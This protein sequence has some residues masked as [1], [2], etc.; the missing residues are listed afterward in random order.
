MKTLTLFL[1]AFASASAA[2]LTLIA[3]ASVSPTMPGINQGSATSL[4]AF[5]QNRTF[6]QFDAKGSLPAGTVPSHI[7][8][9]VLRLYVEQVSG[10]LP[11]KATVFV[12]TANGLWT[13]STITYANQPSIG[14]P[15]VTADAATDRQ[16]LAV[17]V[18]ELVRDQL[19]GLVSL[20]VESPDVALF[21]ASKESS[22]GMP[23][24]LDVTLTNQ[25]LQ[26]PAGPAGPVGPMGATGAPGPQGPTGPAGVAGAPGMQGP[27]GPSTLVGMFTMLRYDISVPTDGLAVATAQGCPVSHPQVVSG[28]CAFLGANSRSWLAIEQNYTDVA[29]NVHRC[30]FHNKSDG[31]VGAE[32]IA[33]CSR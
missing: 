3:D 8:R 25:G 26:G 17:D 21:F 18:T 20:S 23:P 1:A 12:G 7:A 31:S 5:S 19:G 10:S 27:A 11:A 6:L 30:R 2:N 15:I 28:G 14:K 4:R 13:E 33:V 16:F 29:S 24:V 32:T 22:I 9:A